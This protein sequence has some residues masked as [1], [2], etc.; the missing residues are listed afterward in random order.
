MSGIS[1]ELPKTFKIYCKNIFLVIWNLFPREEFQTFL[2]P[3]MA[4]KWIINLSVVDDFL[5]TTSHSIQ[6]LLLLKFR[7]VNY[8][9]EISFY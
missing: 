8:L 3:E 2:R 4:L 1:R 5:T 6:K 9:R 7:F